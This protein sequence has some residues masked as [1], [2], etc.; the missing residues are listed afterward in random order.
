MTLVHGTSPG[1]R[2]RDTPDVLDCEC[3]SV[4]SV[5]LSRSHSRIKHKAGSKTKTD[6]KTAE[7]GQCD[8]LESCLSDLTVASMSETATFAETN[9]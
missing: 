3:Q 6:P 5:S 1:H 2:C 8:T 4:G 7:P 9:V